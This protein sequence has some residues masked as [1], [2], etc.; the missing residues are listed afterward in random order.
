MFAGADLPAERRSARPA[1]QLDADRAIEFA[2]IAL[3]DPRLHAVDLGP[4][5]LPTAH[6]Q[7]LWRPHHANQFLAGTDHLSMTGTLTMK[8]IR[9]G[10]SGAS[11]SV[12]RASAMRLSL[13][14]ASTI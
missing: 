5:R 6:A 12:N 9:P 3:P 14:Q 13:I 4:G 1:L 11:T 7:T 2:E 10:S 8:M